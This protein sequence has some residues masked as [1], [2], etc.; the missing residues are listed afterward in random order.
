MKPPPGG[1]YFGHMELMAR[2]Q[3]DVDVLAK[4][5]LAPEAVA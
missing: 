2:F 3:T 5:R 4:L 1:F